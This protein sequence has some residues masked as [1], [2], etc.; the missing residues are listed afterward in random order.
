MFASGFCFIA[1]FR[2]HVTLCLP[3][4]KQYTGNVRF[5]FCLVAKKNRQ[6]LKREQAQPSS[7]SVTS[8]K[9]FQSP[10]DSR[11]LPV[12]PPGIYSCDQ[13]RTTTDSLTRART[14]S[15]IAVCVS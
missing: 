14:H 15:E 11:P 7:L 9:H 1:R 13:L 10:R 12:T 2:T 4:R 6:S 3:Q 8:R 5:G